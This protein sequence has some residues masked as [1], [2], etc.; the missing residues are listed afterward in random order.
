MADSL[1]SNGRHLSGVFT[2]SSTRLFFVTEISEIECHN[3]SVTS[4]DMNYRR[5]FLIKV[6]CE[7]MS[8]VYIYRDLY[9]IF[10]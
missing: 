8:T 6:S 3:C 4:C 10:R 7:N 5:M 1:V 2:K 9:D